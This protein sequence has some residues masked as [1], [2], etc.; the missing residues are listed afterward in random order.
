[1]TIIRHILLTKDHSPSTPSPL[2]FAKILFNC[3][4]QR[5]ISCNSNNCTSVKQ[6]KNKY[7]PST[8]KS[9]IYVWVSYRSFDHNITL[10]TFI[11]LLAI[12]E[13]EVLLDFSKMVS[14]TSLKHYTE[15]HV[16]LTA[17]W[18]SHTL[19]CTFY[20]LVQHYAFPV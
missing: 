15:I 18:L 5:K 13:R 16:M 10:G 20:V 8:L 9:I 17:L 1:M 14:F 4:Y 12:C 11:L 7:N 3:K 19:I 6:Y 2:W